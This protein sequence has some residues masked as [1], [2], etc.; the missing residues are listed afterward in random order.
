M[1]QHF[2]TFLATL[3]IFVFAIAFAVVL[4]GPSYWGLLPLVVL[5]CGIY[6]VVLDED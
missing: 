5:F 6:W 2:R 4:L 1:K 3:L